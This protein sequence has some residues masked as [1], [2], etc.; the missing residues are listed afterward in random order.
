[1]YELFN[2]VEEVIV[3][4]SDILLIIVV[5]EYKVK[6]KMVRDIDEGVKI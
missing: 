1:M 5:V 4:E 6:R 3:N 2:F